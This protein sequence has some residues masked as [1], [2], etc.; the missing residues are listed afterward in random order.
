MSSGAFGAANIAARHPDLFGTAVSLS[1]Y[2]RA[3]GPVFAGDARAVTLNSPYQLVADQPAAR[4][5]RYVL[6]VGES[7]P[8]RTATV[9]FATLLDRFL[10]PHALRL[11]PGGHGGSAWIRE[12][13]V[14][15][16]LVAPDLARHAPALTRVR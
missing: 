15:M 6:V 2:F 9:Q 5:V 11:V 7:D 12:L 1:G 8:Y 13:Q 3:T 10:V 16:E 4:A 14:A